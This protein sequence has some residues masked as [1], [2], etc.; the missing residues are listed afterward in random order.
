MKILIA[1]GGGFIGSALIPFLLKKGIECDVVDLFWYGN[2]LPKSVRW[3]KKNLFHLTAD[4][5]TGYKQIICLAGISS[6][7]MA[8]F[9]PAANFIYNSALPVYLAYQARLAKVKRFIFASSCSVYHNT[10][11]FATERFIPI[12]KSAY[13]LSKLQAE[14]GLLQLIDINFSIIIL[15]LGTVSGISPRMRFDLAVNTMFA[16]SMVQS[17]IRINDPNAWRPIV[18][19]NDACDAFYKSII[20]NE[21]INGIFNIASFNMSVG[22]LGLQVK[23]YLEKMAKKKISLVTRNR[24]EVRNYRVSLQKAKKVLRFNPRYSLEDIVSDLYSNR[25]QFQNFSNEDYQNLK[26]FKKISKLNQFKFWM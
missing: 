18:H 21:K 19:I 23:K 12:T 25:L 20:A 5:L 2:F 16:T 15:R 8:E 4:D 7:P 3:K 10:K 14:S 13:G 17:R 11:R 1:G 6:D 22:R 26:I 24:E 9:S